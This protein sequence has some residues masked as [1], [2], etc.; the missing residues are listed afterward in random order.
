MNLKQKAVAEFVAEVIK[1]GLKCYVVKSGEYGFYVGNNGR[2]VYFD[3]SG[4]FTTIKLS[5]CYKPIEPSDGTMVGTGWGIADSKNL[6]NWDDLEQ[7]TLHNVPRWAIG[8]CEVRYLTLDDKLK[9]AAKFGI[10]Y[11]LVEI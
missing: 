5:G 1:Q 4:Y 11:N 7:Y 6:I 10:K 2:I 3:V 9:N 8:S